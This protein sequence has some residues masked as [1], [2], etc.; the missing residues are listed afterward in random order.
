MP[1]HQLIDDCSPEI[2]KSFK[3]KR[4]LYYRNSKPLGIAKSR[5]VAIKKSKHKY[6]FFTDGDCV[7]NP[8]WLVEGKKYLDEG[9]L[10]VEGKTVYLSKK[11]SVSD[12]I[13]QNLNGK[14]WMTCNIAYRKSIIKSERGF[15][16]VFE[17][18]LEDRDLAQ[19]IRKHGS[20]FFNKKML[21]HHQI[22][23]WTLEKMISSSKNLGIS[24]VY[25]LKKHPKDKEN[26]L[27]F[28]IYPT[29][30]VGIL[31]PVSYIYKAFRDNVRSYE[32]LR[33]LAMYY[34]GHLVERYYI[35]KTASQQ[36]IFAI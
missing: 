22:K 35:W 18:M 26:R 15:D 14:K 32:D 9:Y 11:T 23:K 8:N 2:A 34:L 20:I 5:N 30:I 27:F 10:G 12:K 28:I 13:V 33:V 36:K 1:L 19:R 29:H 17:N 3:D 24:M 21:V 4:V 25:M 7:V 31:L 6:L 16:P